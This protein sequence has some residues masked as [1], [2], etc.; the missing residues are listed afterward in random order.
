MYLYK[1]GDRQIERGWKIVT[2]G[3]A[4][5]KSIYPRESV[6]PRQREIFLL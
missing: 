1:G 6:T 5:S 2:E 4:K 3:K